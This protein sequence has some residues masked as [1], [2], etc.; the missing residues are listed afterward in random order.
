MAPSIGSSARCRSVPSQTTAGRSARRCASFVEAGQWEMADYR[1]LERHELDN[2]SPNQQDL[3]QGVAA[4]SAS[5]VWAVGFFKNDF[6][7]EYPVNYHWNGTSWVDEVG[8]STPT[9]G[10]SSGEVTRRWSK[11]PA[12]VSFGPWAGA[13]KTTAQEITRVTV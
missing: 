8:P 12:P 9:A 13:T 5:N 1:T 2:F 3:L 4:I 7:L 10:D 11:C 6:S